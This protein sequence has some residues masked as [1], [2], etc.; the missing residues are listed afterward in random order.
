MI[1]YITIPVMPFTHPLYTVHGPGPHNTPSLTSFVLHTSLPISTAPISG[2]NWASRQG[3]TDV[4]REMLKSRHVGS[5]GITNTKQVK[6]GVAEEA[7]AGILGVQCNDVLLSPDGT[8]LWSQNAL[9]LSGTDLDAHDLANTL[10]PLKPCLLSS[11][12]CIK[13]SPLFFSFP[14]LFLVPPLSSST[15]PFSSSASR[16]LPLPP[17]LSLHHSLL[18]ITL[19]SPSLSPYRLSPSSQAALSPLGISHSRS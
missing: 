5:N 12:L 14:F 18:R 6:L 13:S 16:F 15:P 1:S 4:S 19:S 7:F 17:P 2:S 11:I 10:S 8:W 3:F 9:Q